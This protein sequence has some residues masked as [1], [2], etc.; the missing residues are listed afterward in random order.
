MD[1]RTVL[2]LAFM[3]ILIV[4]VGAFL[5]FNSGARDAMQKNLDEQT[6][7][8]AEEAKIKQRD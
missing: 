1:R 8:A 7:Q 6:K 2:T 3:L 4:G 5:V